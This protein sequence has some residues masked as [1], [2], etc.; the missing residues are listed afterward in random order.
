M[1]KKMIPTRVRGQGQKG[2][3]MTTWLLKIFYFIPYFIDF[4]ADVSFGVK[5]SIIVWQMIGTTVLIKV[6]VFMGYHFF[7]NGVGPNKRLASIQLQ[8][9]YL[10]TKFYDPPSTDTPYPLNRA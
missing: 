10:A 4:V 5:E 2:L 6:Y 8:S 9:P 7:Q 3:E 1:A